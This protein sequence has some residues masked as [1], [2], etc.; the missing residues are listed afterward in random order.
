MVLRPFPRVPGALAAFMRTITVVVILL[1]A[2]SNSYG[3]QRDS[4][5]LRSKGSP[6]APV[7]MYEMSDFQCPYCREFALTT[8]PIIEREYV[9]PGKVRIVYVNLPLTN[10]HANAA[11]AAVAGLCAARQHKFWPMHDLLFQRQDMWAKLAAPRPYFLALGDTLRLERGQFADCLVSAAAAREVEAD[12]R[13]AERAGARSTPTFYI[14][15]GLL[16]GAAPVAV[17]RTVLDSIYGSK[18]APRP[19]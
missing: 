13:R 9:R 19:P 12:G 4:L 5:A 14:E 7:T 1:A 15:G 16:E 6:T 2:V 10:L 3:T 8:L 11:A 18:T 17:F